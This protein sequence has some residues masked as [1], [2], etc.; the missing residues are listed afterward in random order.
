METGKV[1][2]VGAGPGDP[3]LITIK[4]VKSLQQADVVVY[5]RLANPDLLD[6][7]PPWAEFIYVGK[8]PKRHRLNQDDI[9]L[10]LVQK[11]QEGKIVVRLKGGD[12]FVFGRGG[13]E[14]LVLAH[15]G[16]PFE[17]VPGVS[18]ALAAPAYAGI[19][20]TQRHMATS[21]TVVTGHTADADDPFGADW[22]D[23]PRKGT[24]VILM[25]VSHLPQII[26]QLIRDG[27]SAD[28]PAAVI[29]WATTHEQIVV[30]GTL[31]TITEKA[32]GV[33][34]PAITVI[35][36]VVSLREQIDWFRPQTLENSITLE[37]I[38]TD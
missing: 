20:V 9:N 3:E 30:Q 19:P 11:A 5:D 21:F 18:S 6:L 17:I 2:L 26:D 28:T 32:Q 33:L 1:I 14:C 25:G 38:P 31:T 22:S 10:L 4:G 36:D 15:A 37:S 13:E 23:L 24:L 12:P 34:P 29:H 7:A 16:I 35:G 27:R 8:E